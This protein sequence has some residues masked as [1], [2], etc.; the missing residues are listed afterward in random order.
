MTKSNFFVPVFLCFFLLIS[1]KENQSIYQDDRIFAFEYITQFTI[2]D[3]DNEFCISD[4]NNS[5][6]EHVC[7]S[8]DRIPFQRI[9]L[10]TSAAAGYLDDLDAID[11]ILVV[12]NANWIYNAT[13]AERVAAGSIIDGKN[14]TVANIEQIITWEPDLIITAHNPNQAGFFNQIK[15]LDIPVIKMDEYREN[16]PLARAEYLKLFGLLLGKEKVA[17]SHF[18][19]IKRNYLSLSQKAKAINPK[20]K[21]FAEIQR[22][23]T[24]YMPGGESYAATLF[25]DAGGDYLFQNQK[26][27]NVLNLSFENVLSV[28][29]KADFWVNASDFTTYRELIN[30]NSKHNWFDAYNNKKVF[31]LAGRVNNQGASDYFESASVRADWLLADYVKIFH[32]ELVPEHEFV[33][34]NELQ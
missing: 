29:E 17:Q 28:T 9:V 19:N 15:K 20:P 2:H 21:V 12:Y 31:G 10:L 3:K 22:G 4:V 13:I 14:S 34:V 27:Q 25:A 5:A 24:W 8:K 7:F 23:D 26:S 32:P 33:Y 6:P 16:S 1:C 30:A 11:N 18:E